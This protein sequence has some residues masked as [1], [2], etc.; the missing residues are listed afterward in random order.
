M[1][2]EADYYISQMDY[3][4]YS[5]RDIQRILNQNRN[6]TERVFQR[7]FQQEASRLRQSMNRSVAD[8]RGELRGLQ[9]DVERRNRQ[10]ENKINCERKLREAVSK[11]M[12]SMG[13]EAAKERGEIK[14]AVGVIDGHIHVLQENLHENRDMIKTLEDHSQKIEA[15]LEKEISERRQEKDRQTKDVQSMLRFAEKNLQSMNQKD[16]G[17]VGLKD[18]WERVRSRLSEAR[19]LANSSHQVQAAFAILSDIIDE[20]ESIGQEYFKR[21]SEQD[22]TRETVRLNVERIRFQVEESENERDVMYFFKDTVNKMKTELEK[23]EQQRKELENLTGQDFSRV[24]ANYDRLAKDAVDLDDRLAEFNAN[25][26]LTIHKA[27]QRNQLIKSVLESL[28]DV[29]NTTFEVDHHYQIPDDPTTPLLLQTKRPH[30]SNVTLQV[31]LDGRMQASFTGYV[32]MEC[33]KNVNEFQ[34]KLSSSHSLKVDINSVTDRPDAPNP[35]G[36]DGSGKG[37]VIFKSPINKQAQ[38]E[39]KLGRS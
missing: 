21:C 30:Q 24:L 5:Q 20:S 2:Q 14:K 27:R 13:R 6:E 22:L 3:V 28:A 10:I 4:G 29:W 15:R 36:V 31:D 18:R 33:V 11:R 23:L 9:N 17:K 32:G 25:K 35:P 12:E 19:Q 26:D 1:S 8:V 7:Q 16:F 37:P 39:R 34:E 38:M